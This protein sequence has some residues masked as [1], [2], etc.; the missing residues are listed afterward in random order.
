MSGAGWRWGKRVAVE[1]QERRAA[2]AL[3]QV[4]YGLGE[5]GGFGLAARPLCRKRCIAL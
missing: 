2:M 5:G 1:K 3:P 4:L